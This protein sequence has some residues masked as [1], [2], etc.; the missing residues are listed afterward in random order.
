MAEPSLY[1]SRQQ[2]AVQVAAD[3]AALLVNLG[4]PLTLFRAHQGAPWNA[5]RGSRPCFADDMAYD[6]THLLT[7]GEQISL[8]MRNPE[9]SVFTV[10]CQQESAVSVGGGGG[11]GGGAQQFQYS[12]DG[13]WVWNGSEWVPAR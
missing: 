4:K 13:N 11:G 9:S 2:C 8:D 6:Q 7:D 1:V 10:V 3:G 5:L 12:D